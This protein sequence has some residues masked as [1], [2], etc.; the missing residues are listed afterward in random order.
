MSKTTPMICSIMVPS[1]SEPMHDTV[2]H[3][4]TRGHSLSS[5]FN[6]QFRLRRISSYQKYSTGFCPDSWLDKGRDRLF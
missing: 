2:L 1:S 6:L 4:F 5:F 3:M